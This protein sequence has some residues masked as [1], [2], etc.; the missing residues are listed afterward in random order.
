MLAAFVVAAGFAAPTPAQPIVVGDHAIALTTIQD[1][2]QTLVD[3]RRDMP[4]S[5]SFADNEARAADE[6]TEAASAPRCAAATP[7]RW[8]CCSG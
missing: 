2:T 7:P 1:N 3:E 5:F 8:H 6:A 4:E